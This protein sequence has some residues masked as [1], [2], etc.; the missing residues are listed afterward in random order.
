MEPRA[1]IKEGK[2]TCI[3]CS[4]EYTRGWDNNK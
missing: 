3:P 2:I 1:R 4:V